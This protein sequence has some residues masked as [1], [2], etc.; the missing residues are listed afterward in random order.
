VIIAE[1][2]KAAPQP[3]RLARFRE[4]MQREFLDHMAD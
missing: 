3:E 4:Q 2:A 1:A